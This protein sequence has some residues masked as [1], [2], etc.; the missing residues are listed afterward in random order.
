M[1]V[2][3]AQQG[4]RDAYVDGWPG[5][6]ISGIVWLIAAAVCLKVGTVAGIFTL[7]IGGMTIFP[8]SLVASK[9]LGRAGTHLKNNPMGPLALETTALLFGGLAIAFGV[10]QV[11]PNWFFPVMLITIGCRYLMFQT[12]YGL[13]LYWLLGVLLALPGVAFMFLPTQPVW[14][15]LT[16]GVVETAIG[17]WLLRA[18]LSE[19]TY[20]APR[21]H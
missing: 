19:A 5:V 14:P 21:H 2:E 11:N 17:A 15:A 4:M 13:K 18:A 10:S 12:L 8:L 1:N 20:D 7:F 6:T 3:S 16:G 9:A